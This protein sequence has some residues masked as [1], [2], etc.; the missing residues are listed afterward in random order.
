MS[1]TLVFGEAD[2]VTGQPVVNGFVVADIGVTTTES[3]PGY[4][5]GGRVEL[6]SSGLAP[7]VINAVQD[8]SSIVVGIMCRGDTSFDDCDNVVIALRGNGG[9]QRRIDIGPVWGNAGPTLDLPEVTQTGE[10]ATTSVADPPDNPAFDIYTNRNPHSGPTFYERAGPSGSWSTSSAPAGFECKVRSWRPL[11]TAQS[12]TEI[13]WSVEL[14]IPISAAGWITLGDE[15]GIFVDVIRCFRATFSGT[16]YYGSTQYKFPPSAADLPDSIDTSTDIPAASFARGLKGAM[17]SEG[18]GVRIKGGSMGIGCRFGGATTLGNEIN[19]KTSIPS[20]N[21]QIVAMLESTGAAANGIVAEVRMANWGLGPPN[22][23]DWQLAPGCD[24]QSLPK[25]VGTG[26]PASPSSA[27]VE[28][29]NNWPAAAVPIEYKDHK[30]QCMWVQ[31]RGTTDP[32]VFSQSSARRNMDFTGF[33]EEEREAEISAV[34]YPK[35]EDGSDSHEFMLRTRCRKIV[36]SELIGQKDLSA[37]TIAI[38]G[39][40]VQHAVE[41]GMVNPDRIAGVESHTHLSTNARTMGTTFKDS[42]VYLW[43]T[44]G[45][46]RTHKTLIV[47][48]IKTE[49]WDNGPGDFSLAAFHNGVNDPMGWQLSGPGLI[50]RGDGTY[51]I[52]VKDGHTATI[53]V[54]VGAGPEIK[55]GDTSELPRS[56][57]DE[58]PGDPG[59]KPNP[60]PGC[61]ALLLVLALIPTALYA[62]SH[63]IA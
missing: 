39:G 60:K 43:I 37:E 32:V 5:N 14:R 11:V 17:V 35:P 20:P 54:K 57:P 62:I 13:A 4:V 38:V 63:L 40:A 50:K 44:E 22:F 51:G 2:F 9:A 48:G 8:G 41:A 29:I 42:V 49:V 1:D 61:P 55:P 30:H 26:T 12:P 15:F 33:S 16:P 34:G 59:P 25:S 27:L 31:L 23:F 21:N 36:V 47:N 28:T 56:F 45:L 46:R 10:G 3:E 53:G 7:V 52:K 19:A 58:G 24:A 18:E 6:G